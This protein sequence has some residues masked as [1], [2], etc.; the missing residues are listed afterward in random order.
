MRLG[1]LAKGENEMKNH[2]SKN[3]KF[4]EVASAKGQKDKKGFVHTDNGF[5]I[6]D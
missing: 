2:G 5:C 4:Y 3:G 1:I 6:L